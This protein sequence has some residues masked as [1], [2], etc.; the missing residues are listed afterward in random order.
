VAIKAYTKVDLYA[1][2]DYELC[3]IGEVGKDERNN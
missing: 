2:K 3:S 1:G